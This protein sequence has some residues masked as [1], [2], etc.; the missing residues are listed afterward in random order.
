MPD[1]DQELV[2]RVAR[3]CAEA[4]RT[5]VPAEIRRALETLSWDELLAVRALLADPPPAR[6]LGPFALAD[7]AR[8]VPAETAAER[9][10]D[11]RYPSAA[12]GA[13]EA[14]ADQGL[15]APAPRPRKSGKRAPR[16]PGVVIRR[17][18]DAT[19]PAPP[20]SP[21]IP[22][23]D[24]LFLPEGR[25]VLE[26]LVR[27]LGARR[28]ALV[29]ALAEGW[30]SADGRTVDDEVLTRLLDQH[31]MARAFA[32][33]ERDE[34][35]H[36]LRASSGLRSAAAARLGLDR[37][38][39]D[40][41]LARAGA[42][43]E[44]E[45]IREARRAEVRAKAT[46]AERVRLLLAD[47]ARL[48]DLGILAEVEADLRHRLPEHIRAVGAGSGPLLLAL[49]RSLSASPVEVK[50]LLD[51]LGIAVAG[52][53]ASRD[54][55]PG[56]PP[57]RA[58]SRT[59]FAPPGATGG[60]RTPRRPGVDRGGRAGPARSERRTPQGGSGTFGP[61]RDR[62]GARGGGLGPS[63]ARRG[64]GEAATRPGAPG[65]RR[66]GPRPPAGGGRS[67]RPAPRPG[68]RPGGPRGKP[69]PRGPRGR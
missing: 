37:G 39:L 38:A 19:P 59:A 26:R 66:P 48:E 28:H 36:A 5:A 10:R 18:R 27:R 49:S 67:G 46:L 21:T 55:A 14:Q 44:A 35:L 2:E 65:A 33:R 1:L 31:G 17:A 47:P 12:D 60:L 53:P 68:A 23:V 25:T 11:S 41:A 40:A 69:P 29:G 34:L 32:R 45:R 8:G 51:R 20:P 57:A 24:E 16:S 15:A 42:A 50:A 56:A 43:A 58:R 63:G 54:A 61:G 62:G 7:L 30:R 22:L 3:W 4:G 6:P 64:R 9:E 13:G 52:G